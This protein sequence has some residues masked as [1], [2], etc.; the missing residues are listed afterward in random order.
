MESSG[1]A[2]TVDGFSGGGNPIT[3][4]SF[5]LNST[6]GQPGVI[7]ISE[8]TDLTV[9]Q[10]IWYA[11]FRYLLCGDVNND[12]DVNLEDLI[13]VLQVLA[14]MDVNNVLSSADVNKDHTLGMEEA[15]FILRDVAGL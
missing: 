6:L 2:V 15:V 7:G 5:R 9:E 10:G 1:F 11:F 8:N 3:S 13:L 12:K 4:S 14:G